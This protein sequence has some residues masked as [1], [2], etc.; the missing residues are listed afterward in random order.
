MLGKKLGAGLAVGSG[1][2]EMPRGYSRL[3]IG[4]LRLIVP[5]KLEKR[6]ITL[7]SESKL[8]FRSNELNSVVA[9]VVEMNWSGEIL[10]HGSFPG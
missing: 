10:G 1:G 5:E 9:V 8:N 2:E 6:A 3:Q 7:F 4:S